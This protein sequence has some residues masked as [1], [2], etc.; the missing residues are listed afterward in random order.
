MR[1]QPGTVVLIILLLVGAVVGGLVGEVLGNYW[2]IL[3]NYNNLGFSPTTIDLGALQ[4]TA[5]FMLR[6]NLV[7]VAGVLVAFFMYRRL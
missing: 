3:G 4:L 1:R 6:F 7:S 5:G 2:P